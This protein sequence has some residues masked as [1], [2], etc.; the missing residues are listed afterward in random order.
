MKK[1]LVLVVAL[2]FGIGSASAMTEAELKSKLFE[3]TREISGETWKITD[4]EKNL[5][6]RY[7]DEYEVTS[8]DADLIWSK[9]ERAFEVLKA[10]GKNRF[11]KLTGNDKAEI[12]QLVADVDA[13]RSMDCAIVGKQFVVYVP[14]TRN[15]FYK[16]PVY[17]VAPTGGNL[18]VCGLGIVSLIGLAFAVRKIKHA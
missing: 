3:S 9:L 17:P 6:T 16:T 2:V 11:Q 12:L 18:F 7:L 5:V 10:S 15:I 8:T 14:G 13:T 4:E 1:L